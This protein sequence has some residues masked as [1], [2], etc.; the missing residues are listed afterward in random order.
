VG[1]SKD[2]RRFSGITATVIPRRGIVASPEPMNTDFGRLP[3][4]SEL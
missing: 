3:P 2:V 4:T 1:A